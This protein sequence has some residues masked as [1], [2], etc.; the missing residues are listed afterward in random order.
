MVKVLL[1]VIVMAGLWLL[2]PRLWRKASEYAVGK[3]AIKQQKWAL[4]ESKAT[5]EYGAVELVPGV[6]A[7]RAALSVAGEKVL[8]ANGPELPLS[9]CDVDECGCR[10]QHFEERRQGSRRGPV[11]REHSILLGALDSERRDANDRRDRKS[12]KK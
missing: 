6:S 5:S 9:D 12:R 1:A 7:C 4:L 3:A 10:Y 2:L 11:R 8:G